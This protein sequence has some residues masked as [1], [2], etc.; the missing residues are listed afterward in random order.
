MSGQLSRIELPTS[1]S[2]EYVATG[3]DGNLW[4]TMYNVDKIA[5]VSPGGSITLFSAWRP[6]GIAIGPEGNV[7]YTST[8]G[9]AV[10][11][12]SLAGEV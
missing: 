12:L 5:R 2:P 7:W 11:R 3:P 10:G 1:G 9:N 8:E 4:V 6:M